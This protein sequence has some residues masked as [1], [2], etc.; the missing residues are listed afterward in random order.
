MCSLSQRIRGR[1][2][3][4]PR[5][6]D[7]AACVCALTSPGMR[8]WRTERK[9]DP[10]DEPGVGLGRGQ[11]RVDPPVAD[12]DGMALENHAGRL[13]RHDPARFDQGVDGFHRHHKPKAPRAAGLGR[14]RACAPI[15]P[16]PGC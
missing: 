14:E 13:D 16:R 2:S 9:A 8:T 6:S 3:E 10:R 12:G 15:C 7:I 5:I 11:D 4:S 1:S